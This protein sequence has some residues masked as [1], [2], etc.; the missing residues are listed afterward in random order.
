MSHPFT[1]EN[2]THGSIPR[3]DFHAIKDEVLGKDYELTFTIVDSIKMKTMNLTYR[4]KNCATDILSFPLSEKEGEI[5]IC[6]IEAEKEAKKFDRTYDNFIVF[7]FIHGCTHLKGFD[8]GGTMERLEKK[9]RS[10]FGI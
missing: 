3:V 4:D 10:K 8:H 2:T 7:L 5:Y 6:P 9:Y 1:F